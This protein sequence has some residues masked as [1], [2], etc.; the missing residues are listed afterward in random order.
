MNATHF[1]CL[2]TLLQGAA[3]FGYGIDGNYP[4][5]LFWSGIVIANIG[6]LWGQ[7]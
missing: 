5:G 3:A 1:V 4:Q 2:I 6:V 7:A